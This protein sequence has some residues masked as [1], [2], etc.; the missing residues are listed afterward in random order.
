MLQKQLRFT[1]DHNAADEFQIND[2]FSPTANRENETGD[3]AMTND[4]SP[5]DLDE[6]LELN[7]LLDGCLL[8][9]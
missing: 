3:S 6:D 5:A 1:F 8:P 7:D 4:V 2:T 9:L